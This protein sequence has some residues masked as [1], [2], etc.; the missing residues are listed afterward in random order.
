MLECC[1]PEAKP[2]TISIFSLIPLLVA[3]CVISPGE[4]W[5]FVVAILAIVMHQVFDIANKKQAYR[6]SEF[7]MIMYY[8]DHLYDSISGI[9]IV[10]M[11]AK[12]IQVD[13]GT[14]IACIFLFAMLPFYTHHLSMHASGYLTF[15]TFSPAV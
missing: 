1:S 2:N 3:N 13:N 15:Y 11:T 14:R 5:S 12:L 4:W 8:L 9:Q 10:D 6:L 7:N